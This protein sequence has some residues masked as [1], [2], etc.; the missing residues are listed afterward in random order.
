[1]ASL[2]KVFLMGNL[3]RDP[4][5]RYTS[6]GLAV[7]SFGIAINRA[8]TAKTGEQKEDVCYVDVSIFGRRAEIVGEY[9]NKGNPIFIEGRL[10]FNQWETKD[11]QK[12]STLRVVADNFQF[13]G[14]TSKRQQETT[15][16][17]SKGGGSS[18]SVPGDVDINNEEIPF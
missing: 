17:S 4:E 13:I 7:A 3:T 18:D 12:R 14:A 10:Q 1:M 9:F 2:N 16:D 11:G 6:T 15:G 5:L 8:W